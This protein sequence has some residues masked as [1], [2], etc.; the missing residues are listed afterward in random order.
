MCGDT[1]NKMSQ[2]PDPPA[3]AVAA[4]EGGLNLVMSRGASNLSHFVAVSSS[5][6]AG[7]L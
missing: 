6:S 1:K 5:L 2:G 3:L 7:R 4:R